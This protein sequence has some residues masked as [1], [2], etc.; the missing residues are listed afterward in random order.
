M[1]CIAVEFLNISYE[2]FCLSLTFYRSGITY[3]QGVFEFLL[4]LTAAFKS[5]VIFQYFIL[6]LLSDLAQT[7]CQQVCASSTEEYYI[8]LKYLSPTEWSFFLNFRIYIP[9]IIYILEILREKRL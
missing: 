6:K 9:L 5:F 1:V 2:S 7:G 8:P 4:S 3:E